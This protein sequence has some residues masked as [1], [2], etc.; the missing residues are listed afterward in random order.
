MG[1]K[2]W[3]IQLHDHVTG[4]AIDDSG[5]V[6]YVAE[7]G[8]EAQVSI[9]D[10]DGAAAS[11]PVALTNGLI[12][13]RTADTVTSVDLYGM[14][15]NGHPFRRKGVTASG[16][17]EIFIDQGQLNVELVIPFDVD[18][19]D[20]TAHYETG[21]SPPAGAI[22]L[23]WPS[24]ETETADSGRTVDLG[25]DCDDSGDADGFI[26]GISLDTAITRVPTLDSTGVTLGALFR[27][28]V[29]THNQDEP[30]VSVGNEITF[31]L[32]DSDV[33]TATGYFRIPMRLSPN[34]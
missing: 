16:P 29:D 27:Q 23:P 11:N 3:H 13:F 14:G 4:E 31:Q 30:Y 10:A 9:V 7:A 18:D 1:Q 2:V 8:G 32:K 12:S 25:T 6:V 22:Y 26:D 17:N 34:F 5:G 33:D 24:V 19:V 21:F 20:V 15:P 28:S